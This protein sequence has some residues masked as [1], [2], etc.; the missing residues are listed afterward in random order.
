MEKLQKAL[1]KARKERNG[2]APAAK[3]RSDDGTSQQQGPTTN[4][5]VA[6]LWASL[7]PHE[8]DSRDLFNR[9]VM[10]WSA[11]PEATTFD[12]LR[13]KIFLMMRENNWTRVAITSPDMGCGKTTL[14][15]NLAAGFSR[16]QEV[17]SIL[18]DLDLRRPGV[19]KVFGIEPE[20]EIAEFLVGDVSASEQMVRLRDNVAVSAAL[21]PVGDPT[22]ILLAEKT[23]Q[24]LDELQDDFAPDVM[25][26][27][28]PP[29][30]VTDDARAV[31]RNVDCAVIVALSEGSKISR[32]D[33]CEREVAEYTNVLGVVL[34]NCRHF[35]RE[36]SYYA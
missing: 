26:V 32:V 22:R 27:D 20:H 10:S 2:N 28:L 16:Q 4:R 29:M 5:K 36:E 1:E 3:K 33:V 30:L 17:K 14:A 21:K 35:I 9:H 24:A 25:I 6:D 11:R 12:L 7:T 13:T 34:N 31:L 18:L 15:C 23:T 8:P 19:S